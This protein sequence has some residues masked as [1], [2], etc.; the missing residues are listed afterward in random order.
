MHVLFLLL[1]Q[2]TL[3]GQPH[4]YSHLEFEAVEAQKSEVACPGL[5]GLE[6]ADLRFMGTWS[7]LH[8]S[9]AS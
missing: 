4:S 5:L 2:T 6:V 1:P 7:L 3:Q 8:Q 9:P